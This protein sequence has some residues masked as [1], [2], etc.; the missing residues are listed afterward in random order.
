[1]H[2]KSM[3]HPQ[4]RVLLVDDS[5][6]A[7]EVIRRMLA[8]A[9]DIQVV[10]TAAHGLAA[11]NLIPTLKP[12]VICTDFHMPGMDGLALT[13][14][15][16]ERHPLPILVMSTSLQAS[17]RDNIFAMLDAGAVD[18]LAKPEGGLALDFPGMA[19][20]L[21]L[22]IRALSGVRVFRRRSAATAPAQPPD[23]A[24]SPRVSGVFAAPRIIGIGASTGGPQALERVLSVLPA[25][26]PLP[27]VCVQHMAP[28]FID[29][30]VSW[31]ASRCR[32]RICVAGRGV[33]PV[34]GTVYFAGSDQHL[35]VSSQHG[36]TCP[37]GEWV[38][39]HRPSIDVTFRSLARN[40]G[41]AAMGLLLTG[42]GQDGADG[43]L[44]IRRA[45]GM[46]VAEDESSCVVF[47]MPRQAIEIGAAV[48]VLPLDQIVTSLP[49]MVK[50]D[51]P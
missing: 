27:V 39:G 17:Q 33:I 20:D 46:T 9:P 45:G 29:G 22:K 5:P 50:G 48:T 12:D 16:M 11:L 49:V 35:E 47:G 15:V 36:F 14:E 6:L 19:A 31:L 41:S 44:A 51:R 8:T 43:L 40:F 7:V 38:C 21:V 25:D 18:V 2:R 32:V 37:D 3:P 28:G 24:M 42:M 4:I 23:A 34:P 26:F 13:R 10:G 1:M 30:L